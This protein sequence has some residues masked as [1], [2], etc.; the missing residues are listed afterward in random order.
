MNIYLKQYNIILFKNVSNN[1]NII[2]PN[3]TVQPLKCKRNI[4]LHQLQLVMI[5][6]KSNDKALY[7]IINNKLPKQ[8]IHPMKSYYLIIIET[9][10]LSQI[11]SQR[12]RKK[13]FEEIVRYMIIIGLF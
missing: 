10:I 8:L 12:K 2:A 7:F 1:Y 4:Q 5:K 3:K 13:K 6:M 11:F 9:M